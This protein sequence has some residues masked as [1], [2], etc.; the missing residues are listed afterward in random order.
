MSE[1]SVALPV[2]N[3]S[4]YLAQALESVLAQDFSDFE[5][6]VSDNCSTDETAQILEE[7]VRRDRRIRVSRSRRFLAQQENVNRAVG[8]CAGPWVKL[9][10]HD[11]LLHPN[12]LRAL[13]E[14]LATHSTDRVGLVGNG[15]EWLFANG[16]V[17]ATRTDGDADVR[18]FPA[19]T[20]VADVLRGTAP[21]GLPALTTALVRKDAWKQSDGFDT[22]YVHFDVFLWLQIAVRWDYLFVPQVLTVNRI[23]GAQVAVAAR[24]S[25]HSVRETEQFYRTFLHMYGDTLRLS[26][27][28]RLLTRLKAPSSA[29]SAMTVE[30]LK[31]RPLRA[32]GLAFRVSPKWWLALPFLLVRS[33]RR[34]RQ[35]VRALS[36]HVPISLIYPG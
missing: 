3:G 15:E 35:K 36:P 17:Q 32:V 13:H 27:R 20:F 19:P 24:Q 28:T 8:L 11:D 30:L 22:R 16:Y 34:E 9:L 26:A 25:L 31:R 1:I 6:V 18:L 4:Q 2:Y 14:A 23:H 33:V 7:Y 5:L 10:C 21:V 29:A 12:C